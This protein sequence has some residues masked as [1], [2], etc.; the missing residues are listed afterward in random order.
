MGYIRVPG[1]SGT[2]R[3]GAVAEI[4]AADMAAGADVAV[5]HGLGREP[6][7]VDFYYECVV[8]NNE[9]L[10]GDRVFAYE[11][12]RATIGTNGT[13]LYLAL[14]DG[15]NNQLRIADRD[16]GGPTTITLNQWKAVAVPF[17]FS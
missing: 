9:W 2:V 12:S 15:G 16:G 6:D 1:G 7:F 11:A 14:P 4:A 8:A 17:T 5:E 13:H 3:K 10:V